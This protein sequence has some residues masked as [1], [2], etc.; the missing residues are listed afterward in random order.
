MTHVFGILDDSRPEFTAAGLPIVGSRIYP[1]LSARTVISSVL[2]GTGIREL[3]ARTLVR[4]AELFEVNESTARVAISRMVAAG[5]LEMTREGHYQISG[6][7]RER[8]DRVAGGRKPTLLSWDGTWTIAAVPSKGRTRS[9][10]AATRTFMQRS[11]MGELRD[12]MW[13]RPSN[14]DLSALNHPPSDV[15]L[16]TGCRLRTDESEMAQLLWPLSDWSET[17]RIMAQAIEDAI[18]QSV[19]AVLEDL[20]SM[21]VLGTETLRHI[22]TDPLLPSELLP[23]DWPGKWLRSEFERCDSSVRS[24]LRLWY[25]RET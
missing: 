10:R 19:E 23:D 24:A 17:A 7:L 2:L 22:A 21:F 9:V 25:E 13:M 5:E 11:R 18:P 12:G 16:L 3:P 14:V 1:H 15:A 8:H 4:A 6:S 20:P